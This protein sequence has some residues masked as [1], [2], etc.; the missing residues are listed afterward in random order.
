M[1][2]GVKLAA[3]LKPPAVFLVTI[4]ITGK[5]AGDCR[6]F[7]REVADATEIAFMDQHPRLDLHYDLNLTRWEAL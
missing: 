3:P 6:K 7:A 5:H 1:G 2:K 4:R